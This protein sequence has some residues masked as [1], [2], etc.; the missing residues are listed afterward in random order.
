MATAQLRRQ[1]YQVFFPAVAKQV[2]H[3]RKI[4]VRQVS[5]FQSYIFV[6]FNQK[7][8]RWTPINGT[9]GV[10]SLVMCGSQPALLPIGFIESLGMELAGK[11]T[12][13]ERKFS[14]I[15][16]GA[17]I[18]IEDGPLKGLLGTFEGMS[19]TTRVRVLL[20]ILGGQTSVELWRADIKAME[21]KS[22][23]AD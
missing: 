22:D 5:M 10:K 18:K 23:I 20:D 7:V 4:I 12:V 6:Q 21:G 16:L 3:A 9:I 14:P 1:G 19:E 15:E 2:Q 13:P 11:A 17:V 8:D